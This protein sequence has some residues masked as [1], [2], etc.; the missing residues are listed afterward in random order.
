MACLFMLI[1]LNPLTEGW[2]VQTF[3]KSADRQTDERQ[4]N[5][6]GRISLKLSAH[7]SQKCSFVFPSVGYSVGSTDRKKEML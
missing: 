3:L 7:V 1:N 2:S 4:T 6:D 5:C